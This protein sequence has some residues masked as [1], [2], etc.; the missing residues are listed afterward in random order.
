MKSLAGRLKYA[1]AVAT[2]IC[3][4]LTGTF[5]PLQ[6]S[7]AYTMSE[8]KEVG[9]KVLEAV[10]KHMQVVDDG[11]VQTYVQSIGDRIV[12][13]F[14][15]NPYDYKFFVIN[16][17][18]P[19]AF[20]VPGGYIFIFR[21]LIEMMDTEGE[22][23]SIL[24]HECGHIQGRHMQRQAEQNKML[25]IASLA[26]I[27][28]GILL[29][30]SGGGAVGS[31]LALGSAAGVQTAALQYSRE[32]EAEADQ[33][34]F[35]YLCGAGYPPGDMVTIMHKLDQ[36]KWLV[37]SKVPSYLLTH[38][39]SAERVQHLQ[40]MVQKQKSQ[41]NRPAI[42]PSIGDFGIMK[43]ALVADYS[44]PEKA[45]EQF[46]AAARKNPAESAYG[47]GRLYLRMGNSTD[48]LTKLQ[49]AARLR[50]GSP[51][52][53]CSLGSVYH[54]MGKLPEAQKSLETALMLDPSASIAH[55]RLALVLMDEGR[56]DDAYQHLN[57]IQALAGV[58]PD[59]DYQMGILLGQ[60]NQIGQAH[61]HLGRY[62]EHK[63][64]MK[65]ALFHYK[66]A[67]TLLKDSV[68][69]IDELD[70]SIKSLEKMTKGKGPPS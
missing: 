48:A 69:R 31:G 56:K 53:L 18:I 27:A 1:V 5:V 17:S 16:E 50:P 15:A 25:S 66:K 20:A 46:Q 57:Q 4:L 10:R 70:E 24:C 62:Y 21:G 55:Y 26:G 63:Q 14:N 45:T 58:F 19:N 34:G 64:D 42:S 9:R 36:C 68:A 40:D 11:E 6:K 35:K 33:L 67:R 37:N 22:L 54:Q 23:A 38:P 47:L 30:M 12:R 7:S 49:E 43:A 52:I 2:S 32:Y 3:L 41:A 51:L 28:T 61:L 60:L 8:E 44:E 13:Q 39:T 59:I 65:L 29:G